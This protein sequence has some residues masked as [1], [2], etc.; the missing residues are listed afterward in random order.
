MYVGIYFRVFLSLLPLWVVDANQCPEGAITVNPKRLTVKYG[1]SVEVNCSSSVP[2]DGMGW[3]SAVG[4]TGIQED[5]Q[6]VTW[7]VE[8]LTDWDVTALCFIN[9]LEEYEGQ[10]MT[11]LTVIVYKDIEHAPVLSSNHT[12]PMIEGTTYHFKCA[13]YNVAPVR[14]LTVT[15]YRGNVPIGRRAL[16]NS[17][18]KASPVNV[19]DTLWITPTRHDDGA[20]FRCEAELNLGEGGPQPPPPKMTSQDVNITVHY[21]P[22][23]NNC[24]DSIQ[25]SEGEELAKFCS[26]EGNPHPTVTWQ[27]NGLPIDPSRPLSREDVG[28]YT[29][30][31]TGLMRLEKTILVHVMYGPVFDC[32]NSYTV[33]EYKSHNLS[34][35]VEG[36]PTPD[37]LWFKDGEEVALPDKLSRGYGG[38]YFILANS[39]YGN[40]SH[41]L[42]IKVLYP[43]SRITELEDREVDLV[44]SEVVLK[45]SSYGDPRPQYR[46]SYHRVKNVR[47]NNEDGV[48]LLHI[49]GATGE[50]IG[51]YTCFAFNN[52]GEES[53]SVRVTVKGVQAPCPIEFS[54]DGKQLNETVVEY[55]KNVSVKCKVSTKAQATLQWLVSHKHITTGDTWTERALTD[56]DVKPNCTATFEG[57]DPCH[58]L[59][60]VTLFKSPEVLSI[61]YQ[62]HSQPVIVDGNN[63]ILVCEILNIAP[64]KNLVVNWYKEIKSNEKN[65]S[66]MVYEE[67]FSENT[68]KRPQN[69]SSTILIN[70][71]KSENGVQ[72]WCEATL[73]LGPHGPQ[74]VKSPALTVHVHYAPS[75]MQPNVSV[76]PVFNDY[77]EVLVCEAD[78]NPKPEIT[79]IFNNQSS[80]GRD[81]TISIEMV[82]SIICNASNKYGIALKTIKL[83][84]KEDYL[85]LI[86]GF[87]AVVVVIISVIFVFIYSIYYTNTKMGHYSLKDAKPNTQKG[88]V[89]Q[90]GLDSSLPM[91]KL[92]QQNIYVMGMTP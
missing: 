75:I 74:E 5:V 19:T 82:G 51:T 9:R 52:L 2:H 71:N 84:P 78:G 57:R 64:V 63:Y 41:L 34:C 27:R 76:V 35:E 85:P 25:V 47:V 49:H 88:D 65:S 89:A 87:V 16:A 86:A 81:L 36:Y 31:V 44:G 53:K 48:S 46:W 23:T 80:K 11:D 13:I 12:G 66:S 39:S 17:S 8:A 56:W 90:N 32:P 29:V 69:V 30:T 54:I 14:Y 42:E 83:V 91:K 61:R 1:N 10:C 45:C 20:Q 28:V 33:E 58:Q 72:Y 7:T 3:E 22:V 50:N 68:N 73:R 77:K 92:S 59:F 4:K 21:G 37:M 24:P 70:A 79:W 6:L 38:Q 15:W 40:A 55:S 18:D 43:P 62:N 60:N 26:Y 67:Q